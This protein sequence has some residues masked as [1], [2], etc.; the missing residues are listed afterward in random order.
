MS[1]IPI[2]RVAVLLFMIAMLVIVALLPVMVPTVDTTAPLAPTATTNAADSAA[3][4]VVGI[5]EHV[6]ATQQFPAAGTSIHSIAL[7]LATYQ[8]TNHGTAHVTVQK[9]ANGK[10]QDLATETI[11]K[12]TLR[13]NAFYAV[14]FSPPLTVIN[15]EPMRIVLQA[16]GGPNDAIAWWTDTEWKPDGYMLLVN[17][18][19]QGGT[20]RFMVSYNPKIGHFFQLLGPIWHRMTVFLNPIWQIVLVLGFGSLLGSLVLLGRHL[21]A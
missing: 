11:E 7:L 8:R 21:F 16:D 19:E 13:D 20:A 1:G 10:W 5:F 4:A 15:G 9:N 17:G 3:H 18:K 2:R 14:S 12:E 6:I